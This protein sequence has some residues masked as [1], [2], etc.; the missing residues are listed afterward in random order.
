MKAFMVCISASLKVAVGVAVWARCL[1]F[2]DIAVPL[3]PLRITRVTAVAAAS[4]TRLTTEHGRPGR[5]P[6]MSCASFRAVFV[7]YP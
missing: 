6:M 2:M 3:L 5:T 4:T 1:T 7:F